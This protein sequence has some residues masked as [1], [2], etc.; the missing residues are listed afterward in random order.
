MAKAVILVAKSDKKKTSE[1]MERLA[2]KKSSV[3]SWLLLNATL[4]IKAM[5]AR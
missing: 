4:P 5:S 1:P 2:R 3:F